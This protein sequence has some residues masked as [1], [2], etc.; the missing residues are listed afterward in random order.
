LALEG[1]GAAYALQEMLTIKSDDVK[2]RI[3]TYEAIVKG[4][5]FKVLIFLLLSTCCK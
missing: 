5:G 4:E 1:Y 3:A 2:G